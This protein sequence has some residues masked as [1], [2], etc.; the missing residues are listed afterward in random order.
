MCGLP[1]GV[2]GDQLK[3]VSEFNQLWTCM[4]LNSETLEE[5]AVGALWGQGSQL[6]SG[7]AEG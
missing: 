1:G 5:G 6:G 2:W 4:V 7:T 3:G